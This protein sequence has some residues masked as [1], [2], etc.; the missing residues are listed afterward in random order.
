[1]SGKWTSGRLR[2]FPERMGMDTTAHCVGFESADGNRESMVIPT[3]MR[4]QTLT[5]FRCLAEILPRRYGCPIKTR[6]PVTLG[7]SKFVGRIYMT[8][9][10]P[11]GFLSDRGCNS[12]SGI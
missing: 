12:F 6:A 8:N 9:L 1:M 5:A 10:R 7:F 2:T 3:V 4:S 11:P